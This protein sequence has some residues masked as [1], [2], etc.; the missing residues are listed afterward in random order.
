MERNYCLFTRIW[1]WIRRFRHRCGYG[2]H[3]P[4]AFQWVTG[5][6]YCREAYYAYDT[7]SEQRESL[8]GQLSEKDDQLL[9]RIANHQG[10][11]R[12]LIVGKDTERT[13]AYL[14]AARRQAA[15]VQLPVLDDL[16]EAFVHYDMVVVTS[17]VEAALPSLATFMAQPT[18][19][20]Q[21][22][23]L[24]LCGIYLS[25]ESRQIWQQLQ[26]SE[27]TT[28]CFDLYRLGVIYLR[29]ALNKQNYLLNY[30]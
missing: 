23:V 15:I 8:V 14:Q 7:L 30:F 10:A 12:I 25:A 26:M 16:S 5:V 27:A 28:I 18:S 3:S 20:T 21:S 13:M 19:P 22:G 6:A 17:P 11:Q 9:F 29:P 1:Q 4:F 24:V 2:I